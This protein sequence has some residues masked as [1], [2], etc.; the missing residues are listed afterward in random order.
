MNFDP[1]YIKKFKL[2]TIDLMENKSENAG[3]NSTPKS[4]V[5]DN[6][7]KDTT[8]ANSA[9]ENNDDEMDI[10]ED[11]MKLEIKVQPLVQPIVLSDDED[12]IGNKEKEVRTNKL[13]KVVIPP[14]R[15]PQGN[16]KNVEKKSESSTPYSKQNVKSIVTSEDVLRIQ[17]SADVAGANTSEVK[18][19]SDDENLVIDDEVVDTTARTR[20]YVRKRKIQECESEKINENNQGN[21]ESVM[22][23]KKKPTTA[24]IPTVEANGN[25]QEAQKTPTVA[26]SPHIQKSSNEIAQGEDASSEIRK[27]EKVSSETQ[28]AEQS[29]NTTA[30]NETLDKDAVSQQPI[31]PMQKPRRR[32]TGVSAASIAAG[33]LSGLGVSTA[34]NTPQTTG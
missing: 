27:P 10:Y 1:D 25:V 33:V 19:Q 4:K 3:K 28:K 24:E 5:S 15:K 31:K 12:E 30:S 22:P 21:N 6:A 2:E 13:D 11:V 14:K 8:S 17:T 9:E 29:S 26:Q 18:E 32:L 34:D 20:I 16:I 7:A 23:L